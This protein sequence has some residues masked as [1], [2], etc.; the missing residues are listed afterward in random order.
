MLVSFAEYRLFYRA[1]LQKRPIILRSL[2]IEATPF[3]CGIGIPK[4]E[5]RR[6]HTLKKA[7]DIDSQRT[8]TRCNTLQHT[9]T[10]C[11]TLQ[12]TATDCNVLQ[13]AASHCN[14]LQR[15]ATH[16]NALQHAAT[17]CNRLQHTA[18]HC[19]TLQHTATHGHNA[20]H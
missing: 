13:C 17:D 5:P 19:S 15:S 16:C 6:A 3:V 4:A 20:T 18:T 2:L 14:T 9:V 8:A 1:L 10:C 12:H 7:L 11:N